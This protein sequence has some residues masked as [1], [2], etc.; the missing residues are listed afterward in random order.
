MN[1]EKNGNAPQNGKETETGR[2]TKAT[3]MFDNNNENNPVRKPLMFYVLTAVTVILL[4]NMFI[5]PLLM[6]RQVQVVG[7]SDFITWS[8]KERSAR[9]RL[10]RIQTRSFL[11]RPMTS[12][13]RSCTRPRCSRMRG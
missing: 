12:V 1:P 13:R 11:W 10:R 2:R 3:K 5:F 9:F 6:T 7:Y 4:L 8:R